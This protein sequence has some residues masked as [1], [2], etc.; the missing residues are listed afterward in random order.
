MAW[1]THHN[2][3]VMQA[4]AAKGVDGSRGMRCVPDGA[5]VGD[6]QSGYSIICAGEQMII[7]GTSA[8]APMWAAWKTL[9]DIVAGKRLPFSAQ[10]RWAQPFS[11]RHPTDVLTAC[12]VSSCPH[13]V[14][15][16]PHE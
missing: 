9:A 1:Y 2:A 14:D 3:H 6:P 4:N 16:K 13:Q 7:G 12:P 10:V 15:S 8:V 5:M 11:I